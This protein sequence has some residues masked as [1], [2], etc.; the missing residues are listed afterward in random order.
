M[1]YIKVDPGLTP[2]HNEPRYHALL[3]RMKLE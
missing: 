2:L 1:T 3:Q